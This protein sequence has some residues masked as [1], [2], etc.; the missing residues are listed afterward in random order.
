[1]IEIS[2]VEDILDISLNLLHGDQYNDIRSKTM[3][4]DLSFNGGSRGSLD[5]LSDPSGSVLVTQK[6]SMAI[7]FCP[8]FFGQLDENLTNSVL[9][10]ISEND[11]TPYAIT[12]TYP[13]ISVNYKKTVFSEKKKKQ[14][15]RTY[16]CSLSE[17]P[18]DIQYKKIMRDIN[19]WLVAVNK[20][21]SR[22]S[23]IKQIAVCFEKTK[24]NIIH[25]HGILTMDN[26][27]I[28]AVSQVFEM[29]W[30]RISK[31]NYSA[32]HKNKGRHVD[33]AFDKCSNVARWIEYI[34]KECKGFI[35]P[36]HRITLTNFILR[37]SINGFNQ[38]T[39]NDENEVI[40]PDKIWES[41][42]AIFVDF[43]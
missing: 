12:F 31:G 7:K 35:F 4:Y 37:N 36:I 22:K 43:L 40:I 6:P 33:N 19:S 24:N 14:V 29:Y 32:M 3:I 20:H 11:Y 21:L 26:K 23:D 8:I 17:A 1:M 10:D 2:D 5:S 42:K 41:K 18:D 13:D 34:M 25:G 16:N 38:F 15:I 27:Y 39:S 9:L 30:L 28:Q